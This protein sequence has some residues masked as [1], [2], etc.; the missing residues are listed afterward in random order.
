MSVLD[1][2]V[3]H[4]SVSSETIEKYQDLIPLELMDVWKEYGFGTFY[5]GY[6]KV[7]NPDDYKE[8]L[9]DSYYAADESVPIFATGFGDIIVWRNNKYAELIEYRKGKEDTLASGFKFFFGDL[10]AESSLVRKLDKAL[11]AGAVA[12][13]GL[14][15]YD[16]CFGYAPLLALGGSEKVDNLQKVKIIPHLDLILQLAGRIE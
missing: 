9:A 2:F 14:P 6:L 11:F 15:E 4:S 10:A 5:G 8:V 1:D 7:V 3:F 16:E 12:K 13:H